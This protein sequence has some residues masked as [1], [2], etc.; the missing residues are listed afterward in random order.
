M[1]RPG[2]VVCCALLLMLRTSPTGVLECGLERAE[3]EPC[4]TCG[5][6]PA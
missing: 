4:P 5:E 2:M 1:S 3:R 6:V